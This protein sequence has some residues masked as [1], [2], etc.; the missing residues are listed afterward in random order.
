M[1]KKNNKNVNMG[2][3]KRSTDDL[4]NDAIA[5]QNDWLENRREYTRGFLKSLNLFARP[6]EKKVAESQ[7]TEKQSVENARTRRTGVAAY[8]FPIL[9][10]IFVVLMAV[11]VAFIRD[12]RPAHVVVV[13]A[14]PE[15]VV[16]EVK[17]DAVPTFDIVRIEKNGGLVIAGRWVPHQNI[18]IVVNGKIVATERTD[19]AGEFV[20][21]PVNS[22][23]PGNYTISLLGTNPEVKSEDKVFVYISEHGYKNSVSLLMT[24]DGSTL[25]QMPAMLQD[26]DL[27]VSKIDYLDT[28]RIVVTGDALPRLRVSLALDGKY[29]GFARVSDHHHFGLGADIGTLESGKE[30]SLAVRLHDG[31][32]RTVATV[33][34]DFVMPEMT[35]DDDT[36]YTVRRGDC[37]WII[38]RNFLRRG[39]LFSIIAERNNIE[40]PDLIFP[41][42][43]LQ[44][45]TSGKH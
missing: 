33:T 26:G 37:L 30:Y 28:G 34:H 15:P 11:W 24:K 5:Q 9:C 13:P 19:Y 12:S 14:V 16:Q 42:Q 1:A 6:S 10:A 4:I 41:K 3:T 21:A 17:R 25:L 45:P 36:F 29:L 32:G 27:S 43:L 31:D 40:N 8:W 35:G 22:Y 2:K 38:A 7:S 18:S 44:I 20:Y 39:V 23:K